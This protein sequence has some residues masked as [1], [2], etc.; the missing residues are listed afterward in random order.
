LSNIEKTIN[1]VLDLFDNSEYLKDKQVA[2][3]YRLDHTFRVANIGKEIAIKENLNVEAVVIGCLLHDISYIYEMTTKEERK[4]HGRKSAKM[5]REFVMSL[6]ID[7]KLIN[8]L[9]F[10]VA[11]HVDDKSDFEGE[12]TILAETIGESDNIDRFDR[13]RL[14]ENLLDSNLENMTLEDQIDHVSKR[15]KG[16]TN[17]KDYKFKNITSHT[18]WNEKLDYQIDYYTGL[19]NQFK[20]SDHRNLT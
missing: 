9:L 15:I 18:L 7:E 12:H 2:K 20:K 19:L 11:I 8:E 3:Q 13:Y 1:Y 4:G 17:L 5:A 16:I 10:G 6:D 14:Y